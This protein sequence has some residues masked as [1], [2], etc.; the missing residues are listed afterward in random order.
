MRASVALLVLAACSVPHKQ[1]ATDAGTDTWMPGQP[2]ETHITS[3]PAEFSNTAVATFEFESN[4][5]AAHFECSIDSEP[6]A[7]CTSPFSRTLGDGSHTFSVRA[8]DW[9]GNGDD[10]PAEHIWTIDTVAPDT[11]LTQMPPAADN[12]TMVTFAFTSNEMNVQFECSLDNATFAACRS[13]DVFGPITDG[14]H[15]FAV[16][17]VDRAG[18]VDSSPAIH[19]WQV[20][21]STPD[22]TLLSG[23]ADAS[24]TGSATFTFVSPDAG[25]GATFQCALDTSG[26]VDCISPQT[27]NGLTE[28]VHT[29][30]VRVRDSVGNF[31]PTPAT[32]TWSVD[33]TAPDT[34]ITGGPSG[35]VAV[36]SASFTFASNETAV[37]FACSLDGAPLAACA[38]PFNVT[39]LA[40]GAHSFAVRATDA[41]G[42]DDPSPATASWTVDTV[43]PDIMIVSGPTE[44][45]TTGPRVTFMFTLSEGSSECSMDGAAFAACTNPV[46]YNLAAGVHT[47]AVRAVDGAG[48]TSTLQRSWTVVCAA[49]DASGAA[50]LL[51]LDDTG[52]ILANA[53]G[54]ASATLGPTDQPEPDDPTPTT[55]RFAGG[56]SFSASEGDLVAW[57]IALG[58]MS[59]IT[60]ELW[61]R[62][63]AVVGTR[64]V[65]VNSDGR[66]ALRVTPASA[67]T[68]QLSATFTDNGGV[69]HTV[70]SAP[71]AAGS[72]HWV[73][74]TLQE[75]TLRLWVDGAAT[76]ASDTRLG[77]APA[78]DS[79]RLGGNYGG[80][81]D[82]VY[83]S[84]TATITD[85]GALARY[86][87]L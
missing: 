49:P 69:M 24:P 45:S 77:T 38:S 37:T 42:H 21:T 86:C 33:L 29:F 83:I 39:G 15:A 68:V 41:A 16:R 6:A 87:P 71:V 50:G 30:Q 75:P 47:F 13:G 25:A 56:L 2:I 26:F 7:A 64:D 32:R 76:T 5:P 18:N 62:P 31:D 17:A 43:P 78:L 58:A 72:W 85:E 19:A 34:S 44:S 70:T 40:Q 51:R 20:D 1:A 11:T 22:T 28:G 63:D 66:I 10:T 36:A 61:A 74:V 12:S 80:A 82:E 60:I 23:P 81:L 79:L 46:S 59:D 3:A 55:G 65:L 67:S 52:Q 57:P 53:T 73:L 8:S 84:Q 48:N 9:D 14:A 4:Y 35:T 27:Y 54:G